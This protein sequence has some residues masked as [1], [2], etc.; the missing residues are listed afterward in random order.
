MT[1]LCDRC[2]RPATHVARDEPEQEGG[3]LMGDE[4]L[5][6]MLCDACLAVTEADGSWDGVEVLEA[7]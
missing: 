3:L 7:A 6:V 2:A 1:L 5:G 4:L